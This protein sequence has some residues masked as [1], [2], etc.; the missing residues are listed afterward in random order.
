MT[1]AALVLMVASSL[2]LC[3][4]AGPAHGQSLAWDFSPRL[5]PSTDITF[6][7][8]LLQLPSATLPT[9]VALG[10]WFEAD[11]SVGL[12]LTRFRPDLGLSRLAP[13]IEPSAGTAYRFI[14]SNLQQS[15]LSL[16]LKLVW[17]S[18]WDA[19]TGLLR[20]YLAFGPALFFSERN[21]FANPLGTMADVAVWVGVKAGAGIS[22]QIDS[23]ASLFGEYR[24]TRGTDSPLLSTGGR[25]GSGNSASGFDLLYGVRFKF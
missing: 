10:R 19:A 16:D 20:P 21:P 12:D 6:K 24:I 7:D 3:V 4:P 13:G 9:S 18:T 11:S 23:A 25:L 14:D 1:R 22:W 5:L 17:P 15:A 8:D 2:A